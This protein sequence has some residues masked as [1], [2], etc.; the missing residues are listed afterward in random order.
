M[1]GEAGAEAKPKAA[2]CSF[3]LYPS[4]PSNYFKAPNLITNTLH[5][6]RYVNGLTIFYQNYID[7]Y[8]TSLP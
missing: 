3:P 5:L 7:F 1:P 6:I 4:T 2:D 8:D